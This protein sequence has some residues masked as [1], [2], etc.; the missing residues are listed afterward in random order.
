MVGSAEG[1]DEEKLAAELKGNTLRVYIHALKSTSNVGVREVQRALGFS[2][3]ALATYHLDKLV[4]L[5]LL[6]KRLGEY[7][8][9]KE[10]KV[11]ILK[12][13]VRVGSFLLPR[14][15]F[16]AMMF[17]TLIILYGIYLSFAE[18]ANSSSVF[19]AVFGALG[20]LVSW[21]E[22]IRAWRQKT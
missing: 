17:T 4:E 14:H 11:G 13:F 6:E 22:T 3:P 20:V 9:I 8:L 21:Y 15:L 1:E 19:A 7:R 12:Q 16:Y 18:I 5:G 10:V 2:S